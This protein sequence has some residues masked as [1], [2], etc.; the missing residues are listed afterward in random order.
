MNILKAMVTS[1]SDSLSHSFNLLW[2]TVSPILLPLIFTLIFLGVGLIVANLIS[3]KVGAI[4]KKTK[5]DALLDKILA[6]VLKITGTKIN[7]GIVIGSSI[8]WFLV[9]LVLIAGLD[10]ADLHG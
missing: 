7:S 3:D 10:L 2:S 6:P 1:A 8:K 9:A 5:I 4:V